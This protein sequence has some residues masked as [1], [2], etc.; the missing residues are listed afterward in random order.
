MLSVTGAVGRKG[1]KGCKAFPPE[2][3]EI[4][5]LTRKERLHEET[6]PFY[7]NPYPLV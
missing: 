4:R 5:L 3:F 2:Q 1:W 6:I 7:H